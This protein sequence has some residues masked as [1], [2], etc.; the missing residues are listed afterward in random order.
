MKRLSLLLLALL[1]SCNSPSLIMDQEHE[2][3][4]G[5]NDRGDVCLSWERGEKVVHIWPNIPGC[6]QV[7]IIHPESCDPDNCPIPPPS[8]GS[9]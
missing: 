2:F 5:N 1:A 4:R 7:L 6:K 9:F 3:F 8:Q